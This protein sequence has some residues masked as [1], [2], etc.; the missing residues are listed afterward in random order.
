M[1]VLRRDNISIDAN[2]W[3]QEQFTEGSKLVVRLRIGAL[4]SELR[5]GFGG[6]GTGATTDDDEGEFLGSVG[7]RGPGFE[8]TENGSRE[9]EEAEVAGLE[10]RRTARH[11]GGR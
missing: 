6:N 10:L 3:L 11:Y 8:F 1:G 9:R 5:R 4:L 2:P 7:N